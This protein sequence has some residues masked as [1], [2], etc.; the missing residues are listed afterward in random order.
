VGL[1]PEILMQGD[2]GLVTIE[3]TNTGTDSAS[4]DS[5]FLFSDGVV[6]LN[7]G[8]YQS[9]GSLGGG[10]KMTFTFTIRADVK[11]GVYYP[12]FSLGFRE[13]GSDSL[14]Y[15]F[16]IKVESSVLQLSVIAAP[17]T[18]S[19]GRKDEI[20]LSVGNPRENSLTGL[21]IIP[22]GD[23]FTSA[24]KSVFVGDLLPG[25]SMIVKFNVTPT[26]ATNLTFTAQYRNGMNDHSTMVSLPVDFGIDKTRADPV[27]NN[28]Q[29]TLSGSVYSLT[30]D[31]T[32]AGLTP[33][34]GVVVSVGKPA[35]AVD[36]NP[37]SPLGSL[38]PD[39]LSSFEVTFT[40]SNIT[41]VPLVI[42]YKDLDGNE[43]QKSTMVRLD[44]GGFTDAGTTGGGGS[45]NLPILPILI[46]IL[47]AVAIIIAYQWGLFH[48]KS[49]K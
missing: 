2:E 9:L 32:N 42:I 40:A 46:L 19:P 34:R 3:V 39:D 33:A 28:I 10:N 29:L 20:S 18:F 22:E 48:K 47:A 36:P 41:E 15:R 45:D 43:F 5:A 24:Q 27:V 44:S 35:L 31:V 4:L 8:A 14:R 49:R 17:D 30:G 13:P 6:A 25:K 38:A 1:Y 21:V 26:I 12:Q 23:G 37:V 16:P 7:S 11:D